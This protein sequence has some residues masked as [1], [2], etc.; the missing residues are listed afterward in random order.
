VTR[1][2][3]GRT[4]A[5]AMCVGTAGCTAPT[6]AGPLELSFYYDVNLGRDDQV[7]AFETICRRAAAAGYTKVMLSDTH[8]ARLDAMD[9]HYR[10]NAGHVRELAT[11]L[12]LEVVPLVF[13]VGRSNQMLG[14]DPNLAEGLP[15]RR[16]LFVV[17]GG[18]ARLVADPAVGLSASPSWS[19]AAVRI[20]N[21][22]ATTAVSAGRGRFRFAVPVA[23]FRCY[24]A[25]VR[26]RS[27]GFEGKA[28]FYPMGDEQTLYYTNPLG[29]EPTQDWKTYDLVFDSLDHDLVTVWMG[30]WKGTAGELDWTDW[31]IEEVGLLNVL[32]RPGAPCVVEGRVEGRD[33]EPIHDPALQP[34][35]GDHVYSEWHEPPVIRTGLPDGTQLRVS[36]YQPCFLF[37]G[38]TT[39][40]PS[41]SG[42]IALLG[43]EA[44]RVKQM[45]DARGYL[46]GH[47][48]I[49][50]FN[51]DPSC[52]AQGADAGAVLAAHMRRC[53]PLLGGAQAYIWSDMFDPF[54]NAQADYYLVRGDLKGSWEG[55]DPK[56]IILNWDANHRGE[57]LRFFSQRGHRQIIAGYYDSELSE[58]EDWLAAARGVPG[59]VGVMYTTWKHRYDDLEKFAAIV[60]ARAGGG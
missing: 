38:T 26:I 11:Q 56:A 9:D 40:C 36:W 42:T 25:S 24:H 6:H 15:V 35:L 10:A 17:H 2:W 5:L 12:G 54:H 16:A 27:R 45:W 28:Q 59:V 21:G 49:R 23:R 60:K 18:E 8:L 43:D 39:C 32:R 14:R 7:Q 29:I 20:A 34:G 31:R 3:I 52:A 58:L 22:V 30:V 13:Q 33:Y 46:L 19:D 50:C 47:D 55:L 1:S 51:W 57:S 41:D 48:E 4:L 44:T 37:K 53:L